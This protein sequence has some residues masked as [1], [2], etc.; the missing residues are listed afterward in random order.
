LVIVNAIELALQAAAQAKRLFPEWSVEIEQGS[1]HKA[2]GLADLYALLSL[3]H[4]FDNIYA[5]R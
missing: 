4:R 1:K 3:N 5:A 2:T